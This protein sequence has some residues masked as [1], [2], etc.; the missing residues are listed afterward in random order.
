M[1]ASGTSGQKVSIH[2]GLNLSI[3]DGWWPEGHTGFNGWAIN[4][5]D[6]TEDLDPN[7][8]DARDARSLYE[9]L[10]RS[11]VPSFYERDERGVPPLW[12]RRMR[13]T[14][15]QLVPQFSAD[16]MVIEYIEKMYDKISASEMRQAAVGGR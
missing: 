14:L 7:E 5:T 2:G 1:E 8:Q 12:V 10:E 13:N 3:L 9:I 4:P 11:V 6:Q 15:K 16:R